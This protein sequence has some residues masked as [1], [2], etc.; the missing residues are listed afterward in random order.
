MR[1]YRGNNALWAF[2]LAWAI[3]LTGGLAF[4]GASARLRDAGEPDRAETGS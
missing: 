2:N 4:S 3:L 1:F